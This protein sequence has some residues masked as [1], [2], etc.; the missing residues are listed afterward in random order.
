M[1]SPVILLPPPAAAEV[2]LRSFEGMDG[3]IARPESLGR[4]L[5]PGRLVRSPTWLL[6]PTLGVADG[7]PTPTPEPRPAAPLAVEIGRADGLGRGRHWS[8]R[9]GSGSARPRRPCWRTRL[10]FRFASDLLA[11]VAGG[12]DRRQE[13]EDADVDQKR[14]DPG[15]GR[16]PQVAFFFGFRTSFGAAGSASSAGFGGLGR[17]PLRASAPWPSPCRSRELAGGFSAFGSG[18][19]AGATARPGSSVGDAPSSASARGVVSIANGE[20]AAADDV[21]EGSSARS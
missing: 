18:G 11:G 4:D 21:G 2:P 13:A 17:R 9:R 19:G 16:E 5:Q 1:T 15:R 6:A 20:G 7:A 10:E 12:H 3:S 14:G 8:G